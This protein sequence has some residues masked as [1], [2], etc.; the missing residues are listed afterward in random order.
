MFQLEVLTYIWGL[1][2]LLEGYQIGKEKDDVK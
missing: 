1:V 2:G